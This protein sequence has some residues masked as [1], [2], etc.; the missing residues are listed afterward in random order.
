MSTLIKA[1]LACGALALVLASW[2]AIAVAFDWLAAGGSEPWSKLM[3]AQVRLD[4]ERTKNVIESNRR[5]DE[6]RR[7]AELEEQAMA[8]RR[9][10]VKACIDA[11][12]ELVTGWVSDELEARFTDECIKSEASTP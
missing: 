12:K 8:A 7:A 11:K 2:N 5:R 3:E 9:A 10:R 4:S 6:E 1:W